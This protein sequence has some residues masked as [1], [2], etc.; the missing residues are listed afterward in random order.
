MRLK[1]IFFFS[2]RGRGDG[3]ETYDQ[4]LVYIECLQYFCA[5]YILPYNASR[6]NSER[7]MRITQVRDDG[8]VN[9]MR[10]LKIEQ[11]VEQMKRK[12]KHNWSLI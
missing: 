3:N 8:K 12:L 9:T 11:L 4:K 6:T 10:T 2:S 1:Y 7:K 5:K